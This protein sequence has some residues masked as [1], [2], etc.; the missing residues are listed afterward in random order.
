[1]A[2]LLVTLSMWLAFWAQTHG[3]LV[4]ASAS[5]VSGAPA[6]VAEC[7]SDYPCFSPVLQ[8]LETAVPIIE[9]KH[10]QYWV[11]DRSTHRGRLYD[12][13]SQACTILGWVAFTVVAGGALQR[14]RRSD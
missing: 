5:A 6:K 14:F 13:L 7:T 9:F 12:F 10:A 3:A 11:P 4:P 1:M 8:G 2:V